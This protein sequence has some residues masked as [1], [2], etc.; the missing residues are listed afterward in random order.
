VKNVNPVGGT[1]DT[2]SQSFRGALRFIPGDNVLVDF[3]VNYTKDEQGLPEDV[4]NGMLNASS[5]GLSAAA[6]FPGGLNEVGFYP[7]NLRRVNHDLKESLS[8]EFLTLVGRVEIDAG[9]ATITSVTGYLDTEFTSTDNDLDGTSHG[10]LD[11]DRNVETDSFSQEIRL[12]GDIGANDSINWVIGGIYAEDDKNQMFSVRVGTDGFLGLPPDFPIDTGDITFNTES[13]AI[14]GELTW[15]VNDRWTLTGG[16]RYTEDDVS[17][18]VEGINFGTPDIPGD[19]EVDFTDFSPR[20]TVTFAVNDD[21]NVYAAVSKGY[22]AGGLQLNVTQQLPV[23]DFQEEEI[24][25]YEAGLKLIALNGRLRSNLS[26]FRMDWEDLQVSSNTPIIDPD[27]NEI[28]FL[29]VTRNAAGATSEGFEFDIRVLP[30][31]SFEIGAAVGYL[32]AKFDTFTDAFVLGQTV[33][34]SG[35]RIPRAPKWTVNVDAELRA[36]MATFGDALS[37]LGEGFVRAEWSYRSK[38]IPVLDSLVPNPQQLIAEEFDVLHLRAGFGTDR[39]RVSAYVENVTDELYFTNF[40]GFGFSGARINPTYRT[41]G[42]NFNVYF[43]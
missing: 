32:D 26:I 31:P 2:E 4:P 1:S 7:D 30:V 38:S 35:E 6:G 17:Q 5:A 20:V 43:H 33:D 18:H 8:N 36:S 34:L 10:F 41:Y 9:W 13:W 11:Q 19:G 24:W 15:A 27:T 25:N 23:F 39:Y 28:T 3:T 29:N 16:G 12:A 37:G 42:V 14:F 40:T 22:K 21:V